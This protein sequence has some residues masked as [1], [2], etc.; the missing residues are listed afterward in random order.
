MNSGAPPT[1]G[2]K[3]HLGAPVGAPGWLAP[4]ALAA[5]VDRCQRD[6]QMSAIERNLIGYLDHLREDL[7]DQ[8][9]GVDTVTGIAFCGCGDCE[10]REVLAHVVP[11]LTDLVARQ[12]HTTPP[13]EGHQR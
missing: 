10:A 13:P 3:D 9:Q 1:A 6:A 12:L 7:F 5:L 11:P 2:H 4:Q 8:G